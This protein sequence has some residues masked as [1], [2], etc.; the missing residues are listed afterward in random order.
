MRRHRGR[1]PAVSLV[2]TIDVPAPP[3]PALEAYYDG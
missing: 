2:L 3:R 1:A